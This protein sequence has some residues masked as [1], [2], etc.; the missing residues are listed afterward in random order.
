VPGVIS[1]VSIKAGDTVKAGD[2]LLGVEAMK[3]ETVIHADRDGT[4]SEL[5]WRRATAWMPRTLLIVPWLGAGHY[6]QAR[7]RRAEKPLSHPDTLIAKPR[8][9]QHGGLLERLSRCAITT[10]GITVFGMG[11]GAAAAVQG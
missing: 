6:R 5:W 10:P 4:V 9:F 8:R 1:T 2:P 7:P 11:F 3:M